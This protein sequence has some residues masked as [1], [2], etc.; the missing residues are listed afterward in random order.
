MNELDTYIP[1]KKGCI[2]TR[3]FFIK[4]QLL[5]TSSEKEKYSKHFTKLE[6][7]EAGDFYTTANQI[8]QRDKGNVVAV[9]RRR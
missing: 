2:S 1:P 7:K 8:G 3:F 6:T 4:T 5:R 9:M